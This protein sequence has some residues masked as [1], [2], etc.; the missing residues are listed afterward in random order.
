MSD[1]NEFK[2]SQNSN[3]NDWG[4][5]SNDNSW[6]SSYSNSDD[7]S[8]GNN[9]SGYNNQSGWGGNGYNSQS[10]WNNNSYNS[11]SDWSN[12]NNQNGYRN[13]NSNQNYNSNY[14]QNYN[15]SQGYNSGYG[16][17]NNQQGVHNQYNQYNQS[18]RNNP[19]G[20]HAQNAARNRYTHQSH[21][22]RTNNPEEAFRRL[23]MFTGNS[24]FYSKIRD[25]FG[26]SMPD[27]DEDGSKVVIAKENFDFK[28]YFLI[29]IIS[30]VALL[31]FT[32]VALI[33]DGAEADEIL[34]DLLTYILF[35]LF[36]GGCAG[37]ALFPLVKGV[38]ML[39]RCTET[40]KAKVADVREERGTTITDGRKIETTSYYPVYTY[41]YNGTRYI[42][43]AASNRHIGLPR[44]GRELE[45][46]INKNDP[47]EFYMFSILRDVMISLAGA[48]A[49]YAMIAE[50]L[51]GIIIRTSAF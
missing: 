23:K 38:T 10:E 14:N 36:T 24:N 13:T 44:R 7:W 9:S 47:K 17:R 40:V 22:F 30:G 21:T 42:V 28:P 8:S 33:L 43:E 16:N 3:L 48:L 27:M 12:T 18:Y 45:L 32:I 15:Q 41:S 25:I 49:V 19:G 37:I 5:N 35:A 29:W 50:V 6:G 26:R 46:R 4:N 2:N 31:I 1:F 51:F 20:Y 11:Q 39:K 34:A